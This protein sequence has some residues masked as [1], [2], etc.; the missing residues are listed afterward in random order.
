M[1]PMTSQLSI[2]E[3]PAQNQSNR[4][5]K[6]R[7]LQFRTRRLSGYQAKE[8]ITEAETTPTITASAAIFS[9]SRDTDK[10]NAGK[11]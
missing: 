2:D 1:K 3:G 6:P 5:T 7:K 11:G 10:M 8:E 9:K 4:W